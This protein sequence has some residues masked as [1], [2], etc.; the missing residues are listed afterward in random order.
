MLCSSPNTGC[1]HPEPY[2]Q[3]IGTLFKCIAEKLAMEAKI[4]FISHLRSHECVL[5]GKSRGETGEGSLVAI[6]CFS[7]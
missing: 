2:K 5:E 7:E 4:T 6:F 1:S 3:V